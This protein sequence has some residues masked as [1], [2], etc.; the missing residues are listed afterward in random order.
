MGQMDLRRVD[1]LKVDAE[2]TDLRVIRSAGDRLKDICRVTA[3]VDV[4]PGRYGE[5]SR[6]EMLAFMGAHGFKL[7]AVETQNEGRQEN[8]SFAADSMAPK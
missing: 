5:T 7:T 1:Y 3:E 2:E 6:A 4:V 8:L